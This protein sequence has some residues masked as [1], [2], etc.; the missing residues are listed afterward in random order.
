MDSTAPQV[1]ALRVDGRRVTWRLSEAGSV[2]VQ[3]V[4]DGAILGSLT[5]GRPSTGGSTRLPGARPGDTVLVR[6]TDAAGNLGDAAST[7]F[8]A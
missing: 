1:E 7:R 8:A 2:T 3:V 6:A 4:R 5:T